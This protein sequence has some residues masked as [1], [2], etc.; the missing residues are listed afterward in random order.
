M[1]IWS[2]KYYFI[3]KEVNYYYC[4]AYFRLHEIVALY[5]SIS[6]SKC[7]GLLLTEQ[8]IKLSFETGRFNTKLFKCCKLLC[9]G[10]KQ[11]HLVQNVSYTVFKM[12]IVIGYNSIQ[13][14]RHQS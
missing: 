13:C 10:L 5:T 3:K 2:T 9:G 8:S 6:L 12:E 1:I 11:Y 4:L 14:K 7:K